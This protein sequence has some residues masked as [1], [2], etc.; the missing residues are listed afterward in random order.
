MK[1]HWC[2]CCG[3]GLAFANFSGPHAHWNFYSA[4]VHTDWIE[5]EEGWLVSNP[6]QLDDSGAFGVPRVGAIDHSPWLG[7]TAGLAIKPEL[8]RFSYKVDNDAQK[9]RIKIR[10]RTTSGLSQWQWDLEYALTYQDY[11]QFIAQGRLRLNDYQ[12]SATHSG[13]TLATAGIG[14]VPTNNQDGWGDIVLVYPKFG[15]DWSGKRLSVFTSVGTPVK[16]TNSAVPQ[17][18]YGIFQDLPIDLSW[19]VGVNHEFVFN[20]STFVELNTEE[21]PMRPRYYEST[22]SGNG[23]KS[24]KA[25]HYSV[26]DNI[27][28]GTSVAVQPTIPPEAYPRFALELSFDTAATLSGSPVAENV[29]M[30][31]QI[32]HIWWK[33]FEESGVVVTTE[34]KNPLT[35]NNG[36]FQAP[37]ATPV[38]FTRRPDNSRWGL[39]E[40]DENDPNTSMF[41]I[42]F[43]MILTNPTGF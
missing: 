40:F 9:V 30:R 22:R 39:T 21:A 37:V 36:G 28:N 34:F 15:E 2:R 18:S 16:N 26:V 24:F 42:L 32:S 31:W 11:D 41:P 35:A 13:S 10:I 1:G 33:A 12:V 5:D 8:R 17:F 4:H 19:L 25:R 43:T 3:L 14:T 29:S 23:F 7:Y 38:L 27:A 6:Q 20:Q